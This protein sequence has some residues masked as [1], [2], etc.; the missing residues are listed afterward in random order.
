[1]TLNIHA[2]CLLQQMIVLHQYLDALIHLFE[3]IIKHHL[4][5]IVLL[6]FGGL[7]T[8]KLIILAI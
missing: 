8:S 4:D 7:L 1:M 3:E 5:A 2:W 6:G